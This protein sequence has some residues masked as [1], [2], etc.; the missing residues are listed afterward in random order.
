MISTLRIN[1]EMQ[2]ADANEA[3]TCKLI[4][5]KLRQRKTTKNVYNKKQKI[6]MKNV[7]NKVTETCK[8][9]TISVIK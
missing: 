9:A 1:Y 4:V 6:G 8:F 7:R 2:N 3:R 5:K